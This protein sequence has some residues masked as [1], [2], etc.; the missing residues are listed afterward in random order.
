[1]VFI[2]TVFFTANMA[3][4]TE[5]IAILSSGVSFTRLMRPYLIGSSLIAIGTFVMIGWI[6][7]NAN[8]IRVPFEHKYINGTYYFDK[9]DVHIKI[10]PDV[11]AYI[12]S[13]DNNSN[14]GYRFTLEKI[15]NNEIQRK[16][17]SE[18]I[19]WDTLRK[20]WQILF[21]VLYL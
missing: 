1:M 10:G 6:V 18:R 8:K 9:R 19:S 17:M 7:P 16:L 4:K 5:I 13:Y 12:E 15:K 11:Y 2:A 3:A 21:R 20:K 14:T